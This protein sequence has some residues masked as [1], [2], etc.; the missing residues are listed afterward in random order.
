MTS[1]TSNCRCERVSDDNH[2]HHHCSRR[3]HLRSGR[4]HSLS[5]DAHIPN[6]Y[7]SKSSL[8]IVEVTTFIKKCDGHSHSNSH[9]YDSCSCQKKYVNVYSLSFSLSLTCIGNHQAALEH[10]ITSC[11]MCTP[12][13]VSLH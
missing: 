13:S 3:S 4:N 11:P 5:T 9:G 8:K 2:D 6:G 12:Q 10:G 1:I 7:H